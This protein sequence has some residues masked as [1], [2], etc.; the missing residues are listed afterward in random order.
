MDHPPASRGAPYALVL[1]AGAGTR[2]GGDKLRAPMADGRPLLAHAL[3]AAFAA[4]VAGVTVVVGC[5]AEAVWAAAREAA[6]A[7]GRELERVDAPAWA[8][9]LSASLKAG[10]AALPAEAS[11]ALVF[12]GDMPRVPPGLATR[13]VEA[14]RGGAVAAVPVSA[15]R[16]G[17]PALLG[18]E[19][20][21]AVAALEGDRGAGA[22]LDGLG[23]R[24]ARVPV[25]DPGVLLDVDRPDDLRLAPR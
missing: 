2:F 16:R 8:K 5:G 11:A 19:L 14:W 21:A 6:A 17:N 25:E 9:G 10:I 20:F 22:L 24:L 12:L 4:P 13:L 7:A 23:A 3:D 18:R 1:A 15:G